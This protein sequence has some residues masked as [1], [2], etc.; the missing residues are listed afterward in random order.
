[1]K[2]IELLDQYSF[3]FSLGYTIICAITGFLIGKIIPEIQKYKIKKCLTL[4]KKECRIVLPHYDKKLH[5]KKDII[6]MCP[7]GDIEA[8]TRVCF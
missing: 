2:Y 1:M 4:V 3:I 8:A 5:N 6:T 7:I